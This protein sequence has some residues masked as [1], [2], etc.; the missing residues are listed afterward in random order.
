M[1]V[2]I[3]NK[4]RED[5]ENQFE[6]SMMFDLSGVQLVD[7]NSV[8]EP[9]IKTDRCCTNSELAVVSNIEA[10]I[11]KKY[12]NKDQVVKKRA[13]LQSS[14]NSVL[15]SSITTLRFER[16]NSKRSTAGNRSELL[17]SSRKNWFYYAWWLEAN[18]GLIIWKLKIY[19]IRHSLII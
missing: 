8:E 5:K 3:T 6:N 14:S 17:A 1:E 7:E 10:A 19:V 4:E 9:I 13:L 16:T 15:N 11:R 18:V 12:R 2:K